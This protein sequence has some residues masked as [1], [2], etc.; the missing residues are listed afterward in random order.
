MDMKSRIPHFKAVDSRRSAN[1]FTLVELL[2]VIAIIAILAALLLPVL[3]RAK[4]S[5]N[6]TTCLN[7]LKQIATGVQMYAG[8]F[9]QILFPNTNS[10][11][12]AFYEWTA[13][14][15]LMRSYVGL[16][17]APSPLDKLFACPADTFYYWG[18]GSELVPQD[19]HLQSNTCYSSYCFNAGNAVF[20]PSKPSFPGM[21]PGIMASKLSSIE[22]PAKTVLV[23]E[24]PAM[25]SFSWHQP[26]PSGKQYYDNAPNMLSFVDGHVG[27]VK[28]YYGSNNPSQ[29]T[30][31]PLAFNPPA[32]YDYQWSGD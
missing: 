15:P 21:F 5:G 12:F 6:R 7:N 18:T 17:G 22:I 24:F 1:A 30:Q 31:H 19:E 23:A 27:Y 9:N 3:S 13:Y 26:S 4:A 28:M 29:T 25:D 8:D 16:K 11:G 14:D 10:S 2:V 32:G 20:R